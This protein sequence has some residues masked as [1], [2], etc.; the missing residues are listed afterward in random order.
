MFVLGSKYAKFS[1]LLLIFLTPIN[2]KQVLVYTYLFADS[3][4]IPVH[5]KQ[6]IL[7]FFKKLSSYH[8]QTTIYKFKTRQIYSKQHIIIF[9]YS[10]NGIVIERISTTKAKT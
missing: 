7:F 3:F 2:L 5:F 4:R 9:S 1:E 6:Q 8:F 10:N